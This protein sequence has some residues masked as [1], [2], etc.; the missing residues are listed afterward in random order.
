[1]RTFISL[2]NKVQKKKCIK[3]KLSVCTFFL[4]VLEIVFEKKNR[5]LNY[6]NL[7]KEN[8]YTSFFFQLF[9]SQTMFLSK[10]VLSVNSE[11]IY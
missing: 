10:G 11:K 4:I 2:I 6:I 3:N 5:D 7:I 1:M 9:I 8:K